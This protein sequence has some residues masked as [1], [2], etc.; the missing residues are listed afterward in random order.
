MFES[1]SNSFFKCI[2]SLPKLAYE[3]DNIARDSI[4][5]QLMLQKDISFEYR[6]L[7]TAC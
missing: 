2:L 1:R 5:L 3:T 6:T 4:P 7:L